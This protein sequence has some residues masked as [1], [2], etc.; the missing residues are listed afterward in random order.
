MTS[1][2]LILRS[3]TMAIHPA[4]FAWERAA[5]DVLSEYGFARHVGLAVI[6]ASRLAC[7]TNQNSLASK[8][9]IHPAAMVN[10]LDQGEAAGLLTRCNVPGDRRAKSIELLPA[11]KR[12]A[13][14]LETSLA[15][16][17]AQ[18]LYDVSMSD[19]EIATRILHLLERRSLSE[20]ATRGA[21]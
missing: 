6:V 8:V 17:R 11:G 19:I 14:Q 10:V 5:E 4:K 3:F 21:I 18:L 9:G 15:A 20:V 2:N 16:L 1:A 13:E 12:L 7:A